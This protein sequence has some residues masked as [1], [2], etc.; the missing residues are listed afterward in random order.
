MSQISVIITIFFIFVIGWI[1]IAGFWP[2]IKA[3]GLSGLLLF[4]KE[5]EQLKRKITEAIQKLPM[6]STTEEQ[7]NKFARQYNEINDYF[8][9]DQS[10]FSHLWLEFT[11]QLVKPSDKEP[12]FQ[13]S[14]RPEKFFTLESFLKQKNINLKLLESMPGILVGLGVLGTFLGL[15]VSL[16]PAL[17]KL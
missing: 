2:F 16:I 3:F 13:N 12:V 14:I 7:R 1:T 5:T 6:A 10:V 11:E 17:D 9:K 8:N 15:S 4:W